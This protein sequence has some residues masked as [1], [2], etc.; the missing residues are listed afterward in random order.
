MRHFWVCL[1]DGF[2]IRSGAIKPGDTM[3]GLLEQISRYLPHAQPDAVKVIREDGH[4]FD[5]QIWFSNPTEH[6]SQAARDE[7]LYA[8][9]G[10]VNGHL[11]VKIHRGFHLEDILHGEAET[12]SGKITE[13]T[14]FGIY[15]FS[16]EQVASIE[17]IT[18]LLGPDD[19]LDPSLREPPRAQGPRG[20]RRPARRF[21]RR[22]GGPRERG[23]PPPPATGSGLAPAAG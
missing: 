22:R 4:I 1:I 14:D 7:N 9:I 6:D 18:N 21:S 15:E 23:P 13:D 8:A 16:G 3:Q 5:N 12:F 19:T 2:L 17:D 20:G 11:G 10:V